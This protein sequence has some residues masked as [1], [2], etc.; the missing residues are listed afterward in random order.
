MTHNQKCYFYITQEQIK[1]VCK[2]QISDNAIANWALRL[3]PKC[4]FIPMVAEKLIYAPIIIER[5]SEKEYHYLNV[6]TNSKCTINFYL[7]AIVTI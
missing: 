7:A 3:S 5:S 6:S 2:L 1:L 4:Y